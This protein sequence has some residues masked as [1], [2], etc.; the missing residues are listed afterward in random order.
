[1]AGRAE[2]ISAIQEEK[3]A[4]ARI[5]FLSWVFPTIILAT[6]LI[7]FILVFFYMRFLHP[8]RCILDEVAEPELFSDC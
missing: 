1:M 2:N 8:W 3:E 6:T 4:F 5:M 7:D